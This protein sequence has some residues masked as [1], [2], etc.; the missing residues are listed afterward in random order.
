MNKISKIFSTLFFIGNIKFVPGTTGTFASIIIIFPLYKLIENKYFIILFF[1]VFFLS[2]FF[3]HIYS[4]K[5]KK[6]DSEEI[7]IDEFLGV[8]L[9]F[10]FYD[11]YIF[12]NDYIN[13]LIIFI[14][15]RFF[16]IFKIFPANWIDKNLKN[17][18]GIILDDLIAGVY[19]IFILFLINAFN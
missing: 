3:V 5:I 10:I 9:I 18:F 17:S 19:T 13:I 16:D 6:H 2:L 7:I 4:K 12:F 1:I 15:F 11:K 8:Y 14:L